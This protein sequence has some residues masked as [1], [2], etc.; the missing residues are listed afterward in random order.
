MLIRI[1]WN[2]FRMELRPKNSINYIGDRLEY[3]EIILSAARGDI[4]YTSNEWNTTR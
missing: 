2:A 1:L 4:S 3:N